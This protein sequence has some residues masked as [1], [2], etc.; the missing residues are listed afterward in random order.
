[1]ATTTRS[2]PGS[3]ARRAFVAT[4]V[5]VLVVAGA[6][7]LW[8]L[9]LLVALLFVAVTIAAAMRPGVEAL[10]R[11]GIPRPV[12]VLL[13][14]VAVLGVL[15]LFLSF[16]VP[17]LLSQVTAA[18]EAAK[19]HQVQG[20]EGFRD[21]LLTALQARLGHLPSAG[22]LI[23]PAVSIGEQA[24]R[25]S[26]GS[27]SPSRRRRTGSSSA[28]ARSTSSRASCRARGASSCAT[29]GSWSTWKLGAFVRGQLILIGF[30][31]V[32]VSSR[33]G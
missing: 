23:H 7:A 21:K 32:V 24:V 4:L 9:R 6:L 2:D 20:Q 16:A 11:R 14:Y 8:K 5:A 26:S 3:P 25:S 31:S 13:H 22:K 18:L 30:V 19:T 33:S 10:A 1:M 12:G 15:A 27:S 17:D 28:S 29:P